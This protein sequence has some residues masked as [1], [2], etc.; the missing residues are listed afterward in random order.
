[1]RAPSAGAI[2]AAALVLGSCAADDGGGGDGG[3]A[4]GLGVPCDAIV[5]ADGTAAGLASALAGVAAGACVDVPGGTYEGS[6]TVPAGAKLVARPNATV[7]LRA[8]AGDAPALTLGAG[9][10]AVRLAITAAPEVGVHVLGGPAELVG[11]TASGAGEVGVLVD[12]GGAGCTDDAATVLVQDATL[13]GNGTGLWARGGRVLLDGGSAS[14]NELVGLR[15]GYGVVAS[16]GAK[17]EVRGTEIARNEGAGVLVDGAGATTAKLV[18]ALV[19]DNPGRGVWA[20]GLEGDVSIDPVLPMLEI[21]GAA[22]RIEGNGLVGV[23]AS[24]S[25]GIRISGARVADTRLVQVVLDLG[26]TA[27]VGDGIGLFA[28]TG[29]VTVDGVTLEANGRSQLLVDEGGAGI[30]LRDATVL[31]DAAQ[32]EVVVQRTAATVDVPADV[33]STSPELAVDARPVPLPE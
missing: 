31:A 2:A 10:S 15:T 28:G 20:Q 14:D 18:D 25:Q 19:L 17:L 23:G 22:T 32:L 1:M 5:E 29:H 26:E 13:D 7:R 9:A 16:G 11:I 3:A 4:P 12:C 24:A 30:V 8:T 33:I 21:E 6:F 27:D